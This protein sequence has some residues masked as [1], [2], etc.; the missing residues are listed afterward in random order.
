MI[1]TCYMNIW[2]RAQILL[3]KVTELKYICS[4]ITS[5]TISEELRKGR[6]S[7]NRFISDGSKQFK[8]RQKQ[9]FGNLRIE[10]GGNGDEKNSEF[11]NFVSGG[12]LFLQRTGL[13]RI[14]GHRTIVVSRYVR[15]H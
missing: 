10:E 14:R 5:K 7:N 2:D 1:L 12:S 13:C 15:Q 8:I 4:K 11:I 6:N 9:T 3:I